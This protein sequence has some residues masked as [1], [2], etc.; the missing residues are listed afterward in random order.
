MEDELLAHKYYLRAAEG[1]IRCYL[2]LMEKVMLKPF[3]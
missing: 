3:D 1:T 2:A